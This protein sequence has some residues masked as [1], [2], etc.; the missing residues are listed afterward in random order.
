M[1]NQSELETM[2]NAVLSELDKLNKAKFNMPYMLQDT[3]NPA[4]DFLKQ[5]NS[6]ICNQMKEAE[7]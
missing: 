1:F 3:F 5:L 6:K 2:S 7:K 4:I